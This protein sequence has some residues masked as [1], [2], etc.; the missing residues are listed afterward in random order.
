MQK[1]TSIRNKRLGHNDLGT[2]LKDLHKVIPNDAIDNALKLMEKF[3]NAIYI[4]YGTAEKG[5]QLRSRCS[6]VSTYFP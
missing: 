3:I 1:L 2:H 5:R 6:K 4:H